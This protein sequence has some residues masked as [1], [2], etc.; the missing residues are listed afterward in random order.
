MKHNK[1]QFNK[2][3]YSFIQCNLIQCNLYT[4]YLI[5]HNSVWF[6]IISCNISKYNISYYIETK[7]SSMWYI[8]IYLICYNLRREGRKPGAL[9]GQRPER[10]TGG[11]GGGRS[12]GRKVR[13]IWAWWG[14]AGEVY[15]RRWGVQEVEEEE[16]VE[17]AR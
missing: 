10:C 7:Y 5:K 15:L 13:R 4:Y 8:G 14:N 3:S 9:R 6:T 17:E 1:F 11:G 2:T 12:T 16:K